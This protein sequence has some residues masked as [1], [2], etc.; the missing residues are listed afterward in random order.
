M[1]P[2]GIRLVALG[3]QLSPGLQQLDTATQVAT[4]L[5]AL[6]GLC[7]VFG[8]MALRATGSNPV[9][10]L[11][12]YLPVV[13]FAATLIAGLAMLSGILTSDAE[14]PVTVV[15]VVAGDLLGPAA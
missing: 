7:G 13:S 8:L 5:A 11:L 4:L 9:F 15:L 12:G 6:G 14:S 10:R 3:R 2:D 1:W